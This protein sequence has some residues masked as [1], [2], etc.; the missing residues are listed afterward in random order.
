MHERYGGGV[1]ALRN[2]DDANKYKGAEFVG[3]SIDE[4]TRIPMSK[5][6]IL[7]GSLRWP[8]A[9]R[10]QF[11]AATNPDGRY[12]DW[13][14]QFEP[15]ARAFATAGIEVLNASPASKIPAFPKVKPQKVLV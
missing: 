1:L 2:L 13:A 7:R 5:F 6:D 9:E 4:L 15:A 14:R 8:G 3:L 11:C 10:T 12:A